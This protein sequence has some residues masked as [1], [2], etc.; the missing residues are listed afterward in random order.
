MGRAVGSRVYDDEAVVGKVHLVGRLDLH[1]VLL[2]E[3]Y[4][5]RL[6]C[7][8]RG[9]YDRCLG[10][11]KLVRRT[12]DLHFGYQVEIAARNRDLPSGHQLGGRYGGN[13]GLDELYGL[14]LDRR[15]VRQRERQRAVYG[16]C[17]Y[18]S[19]ER[20]A[21]GV[22]VECGFGRGERQGGYQI[23]ILARYRHFAAGLEAV[24]GLDPK[25]GG[26]GQR[27]SILALG[28]DAGIRY[29]PDLAVGG[30]RRNLYADRLAV[31]DLDGIRLGAVGE[32]HALDQIDVTARYRDLLAGLDGQRSHL[33][34][35]GLAHDD[36][37]F[38]VYVDTLGVGDLDVA[39]QRLF[40]HAH[41]DAVAVDRYDHL[42]VVGGHVGIAGKTIPSQRYR[43]SR[44]R[45]LS[46]R[47]S[48]PTLR[49]RPWIRWEG[50]M[51]RHTRSPRPIR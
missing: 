48:A 29:G 21:L 8:A 5:A 6:R 22:V 30:R 4:P 50:R 7:V 28:L 9:Y 31:Y 43:G 27:Q 45:W 40:R 18:R 39:A 14:G 20:A 51:S 19:R 32:R 26:E 13:L 10:R 44:R 3:G 41:H 23:E 42:L 36:L 46:R 1:A 16:R 34:Y 2:C 49:P 25:A 33:L 47:P 35:Y 11:G 24:G 12:V 17:G 38:G 15:A 37:V